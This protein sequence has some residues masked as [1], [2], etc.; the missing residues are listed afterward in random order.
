MQWKFWRSNKQNPVNH[1]LEQLQQ[2]FGGLAGHA[3]EHAAQLAEIGAKITAGNEQ[4]LKMG[5]S[6]YKASQEIQSRLDKLE[7]AMEASVLQGQEREQQ[8]TRIAVLEERNNHVG[9][10]LIQW[11]DDLDHLSKQLS[12]Q[13]N[14]SWATLVRQWTGQLLAALDKLDIHELDV[15]HRSFDPRIAEAVSTLPVQSY[16]PPPGAESR[17]PFQV[18]AVIQRGYIRRD[19]AVLR[20]AQVVTLQEKGDF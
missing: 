11:L 10:V 5:R 14:S 4:S 18:V 13:D 8:A 17:F 7:Q 3:R 6:Q 2:Q 9:E 20:K 16:E 15:L 19:G 1:Q 12:N